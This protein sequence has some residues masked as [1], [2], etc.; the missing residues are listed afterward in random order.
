M[1]EGI[2]FIIPF[3]ARYARPRSLWLFRCLVGG[4]FLP[5][6]SFG[7]VTDETF[8]VRR[9]LPGGVIL[10]LAFRNRIFSVNVTHNSIH[11]LSNFKP[12]QFPAKPQFIRPGLVGYSHIVSG[13][14]RMLPLDESSFFPLWFRKL[15]LGCSHNIPSWWLVLIYLHD[16][17]LVV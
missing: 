12:W 7:L 3:R 5:L 14:Y 10:G 1:H 4:F 6:Y 2:S 17:H 9:L 11:L 13:Y 15:I 16:W 8:L